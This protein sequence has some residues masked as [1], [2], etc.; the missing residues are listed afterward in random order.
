MKN[1]NKKTPKNPKKYYCEKCDFLSSNR[2]DF[3][4]HLLTRKHEKTPNNGK[5][6][7]NVEFSCNICGKVYKY[8]SGLSRHKGKCPGPKKR[9]C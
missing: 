7:Q 9:K 6:P 5:K 2:R 8:K 4:R 3:N 1:D